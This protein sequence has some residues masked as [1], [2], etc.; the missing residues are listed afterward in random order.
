MLVWLLVRP[1]VYFLSRGENVL[2]IESLSVIPTSLEI[3][4]NLTTTVTLI[5]LIVIVLS[6]KLFENLVV[7]QLIKKYLYFIQADISCR[8]YKRLLLDPVLSQMNPYH[9]I[10]I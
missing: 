8:V 9:N 10:F 2:N 5:I 3:Y 4:S 6:R 7:A 1:A